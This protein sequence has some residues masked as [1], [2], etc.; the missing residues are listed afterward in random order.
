MKY[1]FRYE[2]ESD[3]A[4]AGCYQELCRSSRGILQNIIV[5]VGNHFS[6]TIFSCYKQ[7]SL[8]AKETNWPCAH[9]RLQISVLG[10]AALWSFA[11]PSGSPETD[12]ELRGSLLKDNR[13][14]RG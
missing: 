14:Q 11:Q 6:C 7:S 2:F 1:Y 4:D 5:S 9:L 3:V 12:L 8:G 13:R 10:A